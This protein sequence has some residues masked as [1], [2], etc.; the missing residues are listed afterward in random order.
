MAQKPP[1]IP[2]CPYTF[3]HK[4]RKAKV[5][6]LTDIGGYYSREGRF[7]LEF[8][9]AAHADLDFDTLWKLVMQERGQDFPEG[10]RQRALFE[11]AARKA[12][13]SCKENLWEWAIEDAQRGLF[14]GDTYTMLW[15]GTKVDVK[16]GLHG[17]GG[18]HLCIE[19]FE[20]VSLRGLSPEEL[21]ERLMLQESPDGNESVSDLPRTKWGWKWSIDGKFVDLLYRYVRQCEIDF[22]SDNAEKEVE[23]Q[24]AYHLQREASDLYDLLFGKTPDSLDTKLTEDAR[25]LLHALP[26]LD[27]DTAN[28][29]VRLCVAA[30]LDVADMAINT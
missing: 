24:A 2:K 8:T 13:D 29:F 18:K 22:T 21:G 28:A 17:R 5:D 27:S 20:S 15:D 26:T 23:Y 1:P 7:P 12:Y 9:V 6:Y 11:F 3:P 30:G 19:S 10:S 25:L 14:E 16:L 4:S